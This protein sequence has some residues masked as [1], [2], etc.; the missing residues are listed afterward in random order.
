MLIGGKRERVT[1]TDDTPVLN[2]TRCR[3][4]VGGGNP[5]D[6]F[7][8]PS[9]AFV[10]G[11]RARVGT[12][13]RAQSEFMSDKVYDYLYYYRKKTKYNVIKVKTLC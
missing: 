1:D 4:W 12:C 8:G 11:R 6:G 3:G 2:G 10:R 9:Q 5:N 13:V 7:K